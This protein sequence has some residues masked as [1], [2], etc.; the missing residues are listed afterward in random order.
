MHC[1][2]GTSQE[3][4]E[5]GGTERRQKDRDQRRVRAVK[6]HVE[7]MKRNGASRSHAPVERVCQRRHWPI[8]GSPRRHRSPVGGSEDFAGI[9]QAVDRRVP[10]DVTLVVMSEAVAEGGEVDDER[11]PHRYR[12][13]APRRHANRTY[14]MLPLV[15][16]L[17]GVSAGDPIAVCH[18]YDHAPWDAHLGSSIIVE[19]HTR[20]NHFGSRTPGEDPDTREEAC[21]VHPSFAAYI[22]RRLGFT[23][24]EPSATPWRLRS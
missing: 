3:R 20:G 1:E 19:G 15:V 8:W 7:R 10:D 2:D 5:R 12:G 4:Q 13:G 22:Q 11:Q 6:R 23:S 16:L 18:P 9:G 24:I 17:W 14:R 21:P